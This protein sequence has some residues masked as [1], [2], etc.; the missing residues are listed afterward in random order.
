ME[1]LTLKNV[2]SHAPIDDCALVW[3]QPDAKIDRLR[4]EGINVYDTRK[5]IG[6]THLIRVDGRIGL[7]QV[8][9]VVVQRPNAALP[10][11]SLI[12]TS[13]DRFALKAFIDARSG[14]VTP[15]GNSRRGWPEATGYLTSEPHIQRLQITDVV[16]EGLERILDH[17]VGTIETLDL[18]DLLI[19]ASMKKF[20]RS[21]DAK[22][23]RIQDN[24]HN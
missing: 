5:Q 18:H 23:I 21:G 20:H 22:I 10:S 2:S 24:P 13:A 14:I 15:P 19:S 16:A 4:I 9:D 17:Q 7:L 11:G 8:R 1:Q 3:I 12:C 6:H